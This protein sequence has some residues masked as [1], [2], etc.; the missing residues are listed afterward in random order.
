M[1][2]QTDSF[3]LG[4]TF[5]S[6]SQHLF[7]S[8]V[9]RYDNDDDDDNVSVFF[10]IACS[11]AWPSIVGPSCAGRFYVGSGRKCQWHICQHCC[12]ACLAKFLLHS[13][14]PSP[15]PCIYILSSGPKP[16]SRL[17]KLKL[18]ALE[19]L[20]CREWRGCGLG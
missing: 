16:W 13:T 14:R 9:A 4:Q 18:L 15:V 1:Q 10:S 20:V 17:R 3:I 11:I 7:G 8:H 2:K 5:I 12:W 6:P 19:L